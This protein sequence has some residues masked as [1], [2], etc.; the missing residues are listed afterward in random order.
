MFDL[1]TFSKKP[2]QGNDL[3]LSEKKATSRVEKSPKKQVDF[4][5]LFSI[6]VSFVSA[7]ACLL[8]LLSLKADSIKQGKHAPFWETNDDDDRVFV[9]VSCD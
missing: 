5:Q 8:A 3:I 7:C 9:L 1:W 2:K 4:L 6:I